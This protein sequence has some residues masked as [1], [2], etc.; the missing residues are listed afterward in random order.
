METIYDEIW[1]AALRKI[2]VRAQSRKE[3]KEKL[4][5]KFPQEEGLILKVIEEME[6]VHLMS[7]L[8]FTEEFVAHLTQKNVG[9][10]KIMNE[11]RQKGLSVASVEQALLD[12]D[13]S[14]E[15]VAKK[16]L[17]EKVASLGSLEERKKKQ[18]LMSFLRSRGFTDRVIYLV[19][20][21]F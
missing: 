8:R 21:E 3:L 4:L 20:R 18:K 15:R 6:R 13:W 11:T 17:Q 12:L 16:A 1:S 7:D 19:L 9:R 2:E 10:F 5:M 14:E